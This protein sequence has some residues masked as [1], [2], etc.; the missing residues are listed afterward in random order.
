MVIGSGFINDAK[1]AIVQEV[2]GIVFA[3]ANNNIIQVG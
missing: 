1:W 3:Q 2:N